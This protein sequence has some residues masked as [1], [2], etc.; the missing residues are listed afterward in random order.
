MKSNNPKSERKNKLI[1]P[2]NY[3]SALALGEIIM[4]R[5]RLKIFISHSTDDLKDV[6][7]LTTELETLGFTVF[8]AHRDIKPSTEWLNE[9]VEALKSHEIFVAYI[10]DNFKNSQWCDQESGIAFFNDRKIIP[11]VAKE[12][13]DPYGFLGRYQKIGIYSDITSHPHK[14]HEIVASKIFDTLYGDPSFKS[15]IRENILEKVSHISNFYI[16]NA[17]F[18]KIPNLEPF[19]KDEIVK[20]IKESNANRQIYEAGEATEILRSLI[21][22]YE[23]YL[24]DSPDLLSLKDKLKI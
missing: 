21:R 5:N 9:I 14:W 6:L 22:K 4:L 20:I 13:G 16:A 1:R 8:V 2:Y 7:A 11:I 18:K 3:T 23:N 19:S 12:K 15:N 10:T 17:L 24:V